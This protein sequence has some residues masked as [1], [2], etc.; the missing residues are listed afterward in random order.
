VKKIRNSS[1]VTIQDVARK[2]GASTATVSRVLNDSSLVSDELKDRVRQVINELGYYPNRAARNLR[3]GNV[4]KVGVLFA[5]I[6][7][8]FFTSV[9]T[10]IEATLQQAGYILL[11]GSSGEDPHIE[12]LHL[13]AFMEEG[14]AG[15][16]FAATTT[17]KT[18]YQNVLQ[19]GIPMLAIDRIVEGLR[20]DSVTVNNVDAAYQA[21]THLISL[22]HRDTAFISGPKQKFSARYREIG[23]LQAMKDAGDL[24]PKIEVGNFRQDGGY[25][26]MQALLGAAE[27][28]SAVLVANNLMALGALQSIHEHRLAIPGEIAIISFDDT[29]WASSLQPPLTVIAQPTLKMGMIAAQ[30]LLDRIQMP[31]NPI[32]RVTLETQLIIRQSCGYPLGEFTSI[33][34]DTPTRSAEPM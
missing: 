32:Q 25:Q 11:L 23:Y 33:S 3:A 17:S 12:Q 24:A 14:V 30:R 2:A 21:T 5:D 26:A 18:R 4:R 10:G 16:I 6:S 34:I 19:A 13:N 8:P 22:G 7:N 15:I 1:V 29:P 20:T 28:P 27:R 9:L 31:D